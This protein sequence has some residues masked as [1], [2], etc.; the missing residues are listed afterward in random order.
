[1]ADILVIH[2]PNLNMLGRREKGIYPN[3]S[4]DEINQQLVHRAAP[5]QVECRQSN[6]EHE[7]VEWVQSA[8]HR[9]LLVNAAAFSHTSIALRDALLARQ[10]PFIEVHLSNVYARESFRQKSLLA[11]I[12]Q[13]VI[14]GLQEHSYYIAIEYIKNKLLTD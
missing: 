13:G 3:I 12:A 6:Q 14:V 1:M 10:I 11:D 2:G 7:L 4:L 9:Y 8:S 5:L